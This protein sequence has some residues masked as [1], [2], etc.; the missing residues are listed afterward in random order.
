M[1]LC[2]RREKWIEDGKL[3]CKISPQLI[4]RM[5]EFRRFTKDRRRATGQDAFAVFDL[6]T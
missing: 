5:K 6:W 3:S 4:I 2:M 1:I